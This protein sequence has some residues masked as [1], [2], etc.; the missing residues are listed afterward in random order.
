MVGREIVD[1]Y[2]KRQ[3]DVGHVVFEVRDL[4]AYDALER[5]PGLS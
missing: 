5:K 3:S 4:M 1:R 2:P